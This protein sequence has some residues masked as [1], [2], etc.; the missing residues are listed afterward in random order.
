MDQLE[1]QKIAY[2][3]MVTGIKQILPAGPVG[4]GQPSSYEG[5]RERDLIQLYTDGGV[6]TLD[7]AVIHLSK[8]QGY[9]S[10][11][12]SDSEDE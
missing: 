2:D 4:V 6:R 5:R 3:T 9:R 1:G 12:K 11:A 10:K 7:A 8:P